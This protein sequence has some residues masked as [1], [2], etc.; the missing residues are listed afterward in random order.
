MFRKS[1]IFSLLFFNITWFFRLFKINKIISFGHLL[2]FKDYYFAA[3]EL[4]VPNPNINIIS[5]TTFGPPFVLIPYLPF[6][7]FS[8]KTAEYLITILNLISWFLVF[9]LLWK[10]EIGKINHIFFLLLASL[11]FSFPLIFSLA[12]GNPIGFVALGIY[13]FYI[14]KNRFLQ[15]F[16]FS[17]SW[18][19]KIFPIITIIPQI[20]SQGKKINKKIIILF[21]A[22]FVLIAMFFYIFLPQNSWDAY[23][24]FFSSLKT[25][26]PDTSTYNQSF[27]SS[28]MRLHFLTPTFS[29]WHVC[30]TFFL[31]SIL[32]KNYQTLHS[33]NTTVSLVAF[34]LLIHPFPWQ[35]YF[36]VFLPFI[37]IK[38]GRCDYKF[39]LVYLLIS[40]NW[41]NSQ[42]FA[43][44][45]LFLFITT[46]TTHLHLF[47][48]H[49]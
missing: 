42:F 9:Y 18:I 22:S 31:L 41:G 16:A 4:L 26:V 29:F 35:Y 27:S 7:L 6:T 12:Q 25:P 11:A 48:K 20:F 44:L 17:L 19:L 45:L 5:K 28:L 40:L 39:I 30:F 49:I 46:K 1:T 8:F 32:I 43:T 47:Q 24:K 14:F 36:A 34:A 15:F 38:I 33:L 21:T 37:F 10:K 2:D 13:G 3:K 23:L